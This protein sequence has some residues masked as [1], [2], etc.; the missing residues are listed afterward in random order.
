MIRFYI[1]NVFRR[2]MLMN[3]IPRILFSSNLN[4]S[5]IIISLAIGLACVNLIATFITWELNTD[6]FH[7]NKKRIYSLLADDPF[8]EGDKMYYTRFGSAE[9]MK[10][11]FAEVEDLC[12]ISNKNPAKV[13][14]N[15]QKYFDKPK[16]I[17]ASPNFFGFFSYEIK[18]G[19]PELLLETGN[20]IVISEELAAK[21]FGDFSPLGQLII[22]ANRDRNDTMLV[23]GVFRKPVENTQIIFDMVR[24]ID[25]EDSRCYLCLTPNTDVDKLEKKFADNKESIPIVHDGTRGTHYLKKLN[26]TYFDTSRKQTIEASRDKSDLKIAF[27][28]ALLIVGVAIF[29]YLGLLNNRLLGKAFEY[30]IR[31]IN[32]S[33]KAALI[34]DF[35]LEC[36]L[37][38]GIAFISSFFLMWLFVPFFNTLIGSYIS[39]FTVFQSK[40]LGILL[41]IP[42]FILLVTFLFVYCRIR[43][44]ELDAGLKPANFSQMHIPALNVSQLV[45]SIILISASLIIIKQINY[46]TKKH[47][48]INKQVLEVK[49]PR[50]YFPKTAVF[51]AELEKLPS[52]NSIS[53]ANASP[54]LEHFLVLLHYKD[55][56][57]DKQYTP[58]V[59]V[60]D[61]NYVK[62]LGINIIKGDGFSGNE[63]S[64]KNK[65]LINE[66]LTK[67]FVDRELI[68]NSL[69]GNEDLI[70]TGIVRDFHYGSLKEFVE[71]AYIAYGNDGNH[72]MVESSP[73]NMTKTREDITKVWNKLIADYPVNIES[74]GE[75][76]EWMHRD[77]KNYAKLIGACC[78]ISVFLSMIG[79]FAVSFYTS[80]KR[81]KE[82]GIR[83]VNGAKIKEIIS[84]LNKDFIKWVAIAFATAC[85]IA[86]FAMN[87]WLEDFA[88]KTVLSWWIF[89]LSGIVA[90]FIALL[91]V[92]WQSWRAARRNPVEALRYE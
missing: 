60:G 73:G 87:K 37:L 65:C 14:V 45:I 78:S 92:S 79:L 18:A 76:Y 36:M 8:S 89:A 43:F 1:N 23:K 57:K 17:G 74:V 84:M 90:L 41:G 7:E 52:V 4:S 32:G 5:I 2:I 70:V 9:Y 80:R 21:Y 85:P 91:T 62:T 71:P 50:Q 35:M 12:R 58:S 53:V 54:V 25:D 26:D 72:L 81:T 6:G 29:N 20:D 28:I 27:V 3:K 64:D 31:R 88:Y 55:N 67:L 59:F 69:P 49:I 11:N 82:V 47:I 40:F 19:N 83:K 16:V 51:K 56:G 39:Y 44:K 38:V 63:T 30:S 75:R 68:G 13:I 22:L 10:D 42:A 66:S 86:Y 46:I 48:G 77:N 61:E 15:Q 33:S 34:T 24:K